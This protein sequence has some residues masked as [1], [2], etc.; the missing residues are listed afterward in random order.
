MKQHPAPFTQDHIRYLYALSARSLTKDNTLSV[1]DCKQ[2]SY[3]A[4]K[5]Q[6]IAPRESK[7]HVGMKVLYNLHQRTKEVWIPAVVLAIGPKRIVIKDEQFQLRR[8]VLESNL[9][10]R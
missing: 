1:Y 6:E 8:T 2:L 3:I 4:S 9:R 5:M 10:F 7:F